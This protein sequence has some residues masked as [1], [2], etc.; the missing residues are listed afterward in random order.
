MPVLVQRALGARLEAQG[1]AGLDV[2]TSIDSMIE[3]VADERPDISAHV[4][5]DGTVTILFSDIEDSTLM[6]ERLGD[7]RWLEVLRAHNS[8]FRRRLG[9]H[10]G[11]EVKSQGDG[12][13]LVFRDPEAAL[14]LRGRDPARPRE[15]AEGA[16]DERV[17]VRMGLHTGEAI[18]EEG[19]FFGRSVILAA[20]IAAQACGGEILVSEPLREAAEAA[21]DGLRL[22][23]GPRAGAEGP[24]RPPPGLPGRVGG[25]GPGLA[26][27]LGGTA[28]RVPA[29]PVTFVASLRS[30]RGCKEAGRS[31]SPPSRHAGYSGCLAAALADFG[32]RRPFPGAPTRTRAR[33]TTPRTIPT[34]TAARPTIRTP[35]TG[36]CTIYYEEEYS[37]R[38]QPRSANQAILPSR[39]RTRSPGHAAT[40]TAR[41]STRRARPPTAAEPGTADDAAAECLMPPASAPTPPGSTRPAA[42]TSKIAILDT[43]IRWQERE[44]VNKIALNRAELPLPKLAGGADCAAYDCNADGAFNVRDYADDPRVAGCRRRPARPTRSSTAP[45]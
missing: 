32:V 17:R 31:F 27:T 20:R 39:C 26:L 1:L 44:L 40:S 19:D 41:S 37:V 4:N 35:P 34:S 42:R 14:A 38:L 16:E 13:M 15:A 7:E 30:E 23:R 24:R 36:D 10:G 9:E 25:R 8:V 43:G 28:W 5:D 21:D 22:R 18:R 29:P 45:T 33:A 11:F 3:S 12:F 6:T 2:T